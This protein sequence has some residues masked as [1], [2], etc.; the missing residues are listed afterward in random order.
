MKLAG[1][2]GFKSGR[3]HDS[4]FGGSG[5]CHAL[6]TREHNV[7]DCSENTTGSVERGEAVTSI[8]ILL[9]GRASRIFVAFHFQGLQ[10]DNETRLGG[11][12]QTEHFP[13]QAPLGW[14][15]GSTHQ[16]S[17]HSLP[18]ESPLVLCSCGSERR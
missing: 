7:N 1:W 2:I 9:L 15:P 3:S 16:S 5:D 4:G 14:L 18:S 10:G 17:H 12:P 8:L 6:L 13:S 11:A